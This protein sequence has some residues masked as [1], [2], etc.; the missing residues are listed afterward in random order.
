MTMLD[1]YCICVWDV[2]TGRWEERSSGVTRAQLRDEIR[3][4]RREGWTSVSVLIERE[5]SLL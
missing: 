5:Y 4:L 3:E 1:T 2:D